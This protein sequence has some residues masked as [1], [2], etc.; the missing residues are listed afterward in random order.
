MLQLKYEVKAIW[1][2]EPHKKQHCVY[3]DLAYTVNSY[4]SVSMFRV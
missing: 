4:V 1:Q 2:K 3:I